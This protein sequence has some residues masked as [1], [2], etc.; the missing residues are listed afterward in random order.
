VEFIVKG[1]E[2]ATI[3]PTLSTKVEDATHALGSGVVQRV[4]T[5]PYDP[6]KMVE[7]YEHSSILQPA[8]GAIV[9]NVHDCGYRFEP[10][11]DLANTTTTKILKT[12]MMAERIAAFKKSKKLYT[13][14]DVVPT[15]AEVEERRQDI[16]MEMDLE[17]LRV[18]SFF[19]AC[20]PFSSF[21][22]F[23]EGLCRDLLIT[24]NAYFEIIRDESGDVAQFCWL[25][26]AAMRL[27]FWTHTNNSQV[28]LVRASYP[29]RV[30][31]HLE[32]VYSER[33]FR[34]FVQVGFANTNYTY[35]KEF[36]DPRMISASSGRVIPDG[37]K[38]PK[39]DQL[40]HEVVWLKSPSLRI[41]TP[42]GLPIWVGAMA[43]VTGSIYSQ[44]VNESHFNHKA[45]P[46]A[47]LF[48]SGASKEA[49]QALEENLQAKLLEIQDLDKYHSV[50][51]IAATASGDDP[52]AEV[53][54]K[55]EPMRKAIKDDAL[56]QEYDANCHKLAWMQFRVPPMLMGAAEDL[57]RATSDNVIR[58]AEG[59][60]FGPMRERFDS[61]INQILIMGLGIRYLKFVSNSP[62]QRNPKDV[63]EMT[64]LASDVGALSVNQL[65]MQFA[66]A[67]NS[68]YNRIEQP[69]ADVP[70]MLFKGQI[71][72][73]VLPLVEYPTFNVSTG[74][75]GTSTT[76]R[77]PSSAPESASPTTPSVPQPPKEGA[78]PMDPSA[79]T[80]D[81][82]SQAHA[83][84]QQIE[85]MMRERG[86]LTGPTEI[87]T[88]Q[89]KALL[90]PVEL[91]VSRKP[92]V[93]TVRDA[94]ISDPTPEEDPVPSEHG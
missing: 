24:G 14:A 57:N 89:G 17:R 75:K 90:V 55:V 48:I 52:T 33:P 50:V 12:A 76:T 27:G 78:P 42:Y 38:I 79:E 23:R 87:D 11:I 51:L 30:G 18:E 77:L 60:V 20:C 35:Y 65:L 67:F 46:Q 26:S 28:D 31:I 4:L 93:R 13:R 83:L 71:T 3:A 15:D 37:K 64:K 29:Q 84:K 22:E 86:S 91:G 10:I 34:V 25:R 49:V 69:W 43:L 94:P 6:L 63:A 66:E 74:T 54:F 39:G 59:Q 9:A 81:L 45:I 36:G 56:F 7:L 80:P 72:N 92:G 53:T 40:A 21:A 68:P 1:I 2:G 85:A 16:E 70:T 5:P 44:R 88:P 8:I 58:F 82:Q 73:G 19:S 62:V 61:I 41:D 47:F 32:N